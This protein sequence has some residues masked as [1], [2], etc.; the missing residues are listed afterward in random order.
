MIM[1]ATIRDITTVAVV[2]EMTEDT[3]VYVEHGGTFRRAEGA[4]VREAIGIGG[5]VVN[6]EGLLCIEMNE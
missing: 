6:E 2:S 4:V 1:A 3:K 5:L